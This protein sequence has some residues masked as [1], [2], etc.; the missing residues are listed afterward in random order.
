M[1]SDVYAK[2]MVSD[3]AADRAGQPHLP[4]PDYLVEYI[5]VWSHHIAD[6]VHVES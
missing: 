1:A 4:F 2:R 3:A 5:R 6:L